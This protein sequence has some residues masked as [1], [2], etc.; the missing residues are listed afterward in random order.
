MKIIERVIV[1][2]EPASSKNID[3]IAGEMR[4]GLE[5]FLSSHVN[6]TGEEL[7]AERYERFRRM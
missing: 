7:A 4:R 2:K 3:V 6:M 1:E 5:E